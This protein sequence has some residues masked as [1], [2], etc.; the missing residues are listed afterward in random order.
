MATEFKKGDKVTVAGVVDFVP[1]PGSSAL[2][3]EFGSNEAIC[4]QAGDT[5]LVEAAPMDK[6][7]P[8]TVVKASHSADSF[9]VTDTDDLYRIFGSGL[10]LLSS[11]TWPSLNKQHTVTVVG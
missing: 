10:V 6:P 1:W 3:V 2:T 4:V 9:I 8:G 7:R 5:T 11:Y